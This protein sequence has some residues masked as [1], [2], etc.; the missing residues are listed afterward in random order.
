EVG[1]HLPDIVAHRREVLSDVSSHTPPRAALD[2]RHSSVSCGQGCS[3][4]TNPVMTSAPF[5]RYSMCS[6]HR[7]TSEHSEVVSCLRVLK[8]RQRVWPL[9]FHVPCLSCEST[10]ACSVPFGRTCCDQ[11]ASSVMTLPMICARISRAERR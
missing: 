8:I 9:I 2:V 4:R 6:F 10:M 1:V 5:S 11:C 3:L 7:Q